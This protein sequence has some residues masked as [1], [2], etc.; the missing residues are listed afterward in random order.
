MFH[1]LPQYVPTI[2]LM[3]LLASRMAHV[4]LKT[5]KW[6]GLVIPETNA[7]PEPKFMVTVAHISIAATAPGENLTAHCCISMTAPDDK[8]CNNI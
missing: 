3:M 7:Q 2:L 4:L 8:F 1:E 6:L 5:V